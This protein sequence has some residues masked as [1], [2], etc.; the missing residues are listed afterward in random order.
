MLILYVASLACTLS[1]ALGTV[2]PALAPQPNSRAAVRHD[3]P[4]VIF[5]LVNAAPQEL[6]LR[7]PDKLLYV[8]LPLY[9]LKTMFMNLSWDSVN[10]VVTESITI[11][12]THSTTTHVVT[13]IP[14]ASFIT[15]VVTPTTV[16]TTTVE[17][18]PSSS[19][20][21]ALPAN[22][23]SRND[24][25]GSVKRCSMAGHRMYWMIGFVLLALSN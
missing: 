9:C 20:T 15:T 1:T 8:F 4:N 10:A 3:T 7:E 18:P 2:A 6:S 16:T 19:T 5:P 22:D 21:G 24:A 23:T 14:P 17:V 11:T 13:S 25:A 12:S